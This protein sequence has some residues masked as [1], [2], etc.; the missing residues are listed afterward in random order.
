M[1]GIVR[2]ITE[3]HQLEQQLRQAQKME[4]I[5]QL[6]GGIAHDF[7]NILT[8]IIGFANLLEAKLP[9]GDPLAD[10]PR[11][12]A[13]S[14]ARASELTRGLLAYSR[15]QVLSMRPVSLNGLLRAMSPMLRRLIR[16][17]IELESVYCD[18]ETSVHADPVQVEQVVMNLV[19][20]AADAMPGGGRITLETRLRDGHVVLA[21]TDTGEGMDEATQDKIFDPFFTTK[22]VGKGTGL[23]MAIVYGIV[24]QH[25]GTI[26]VHSEPGKGTCMMVSL[27][28]GGVI[29]IGPEAIPEAAASMTGHET[30]LVAEDD[31]ALRGLVKE[32]LERFGYTVLLASDG[33]EALEIYRAESGRIDMLLVDLVMPRMNGRL[34]F[35]AARALNPRVRALFYSGYTAD[36]VESDSGLDPN[37]HLLPKP[38]SVNDLARKVRQI[39]DAPV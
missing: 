19:T 22:E 16:E 24:R 12:I 13:A 33:V 18:G 11:N 26:Y 8:A 31:E 25:K 34:F 21:V 20:N 15:K 27:P 30:I 6:A 28:S 4:A 1:R 23:G 17:D 10:Y 5:G 36:L 32:M 7:N 35:D 3:H 37:V 38:F 14:A 29:E 39:L 2:D 9:P